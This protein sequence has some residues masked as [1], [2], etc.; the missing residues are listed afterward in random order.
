[1]FIAYSLFSKK[2]VSPSVGP[3]IMLEAKALAYRHMEA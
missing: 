2:T 1:M 3:R